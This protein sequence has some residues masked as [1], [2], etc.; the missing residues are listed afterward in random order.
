MN[1]HKTRRLVVMGATKI[2]APAPDALKL[3]AAARKI[4]CSTAELRRL[5][6]R[7]DGPAF[8]R[9]GQRMM[10]RQ[11]TIEKWLAKREAESL[12]ILRHNRALVQK[13]SNS[14]EMKKE[15]VGA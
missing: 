13:F 2:E 15:K 10:F 11:S 7:G 5:V 4:G 8:V 14:A 12:K 1:A 3:S 9:I 6:N